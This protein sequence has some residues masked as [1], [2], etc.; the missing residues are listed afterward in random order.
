MRAIGLA[1]SI[2]RTQ[3]V[4]G[5][6]TSVTSQ[7]VMRLLTFALMLGLSGCSSIGSVG[8]LPDGAADAG[9]EDADSTELGV[10]VVAA[11]SGDDGPA[12]TGLAPSPDVGVDSGIVPDVG[13]PGALRVLAFSRTGGFRHGSISVGVAAL[14]AEAQARGWDFTATED[15]AEM[16]DARLDSTDVVVFLNTTGD[17]LDATQQQALERYVR[18]GGGWVGVHAAADTEYDWP[19]YGELVGAWFQRHPRI[20]DAVLTIETPSHPAT[21]HLDA[22]WSRRDEWYDFRTNP[23][24][25]VQVLLTIDESTYEGGQMGTDHPIA[26]VHE[27]LGGRAF[28]TAGGHTDDSYSEPAFLEHL[29]AGI[30]WAGGR[31]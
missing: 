25:N 24:P 22:T 6:G 17:V 12:D 16:S 1:A 29:L 30:E 26:W 5:V 13:V 21:A 11:D 23:R 15:A 9:R 31:R 8:D 18:G 10:D 27:N 19:F 2:R 28:Y 7:E 3:C 14:L 4:P 20:Q